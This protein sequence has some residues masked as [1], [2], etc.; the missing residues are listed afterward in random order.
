MADNVTVAP[1]FVAKASKLKSKSRLQ[2]SVKYRNTAKLHSKKIKQMMASAKATRKAKR[3]AKRKALIEGQG[4]L[5]AINENDFFK[6]EDLVYDLIS[7]FCK[8]MEDLKKLDDTIDIDDS[9]SR[10]KISVLKSYIYEMLTQFS[11]K[12]SDYMHEE[13][14]AHN[15]N[16]K[17]A[18]KPSPHNDV[19]DKLA[20]IFAGLTLKK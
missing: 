17:S 3:S 12:K 20:N 8:K 5:P 10:S 18:N 1:T 14:P 6:D 13:A 4:F 19:N 7:N 2:Q 16:A 15:N 11:K 9:E